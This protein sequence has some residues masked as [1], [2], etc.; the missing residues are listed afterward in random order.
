M[1]NN[2]VKEAVIHSMKNKRSI[3]ESE[4]CGCYHCLS[5][6]SKH[7]ITEWT[8]NGETAICPKCKV[9]SVLAQTY[10]VPLDIEHLQIL[11]THWFGSNV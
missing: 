2:L 8:D 9:D 1:N 7:D 3:E 4:T 5:V 11:Q 6:F 10:G